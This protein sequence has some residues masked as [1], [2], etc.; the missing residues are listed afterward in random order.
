MLMDKIEVTKIKT[1]QSI[2]NR[3]H[4]IPNKERKGFNLGGSQVTIHAI[5]NHPYP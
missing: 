4:I 3:K 5:L 2:R 1:I